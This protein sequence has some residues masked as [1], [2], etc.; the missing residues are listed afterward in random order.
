MGAI[1][2]GFYAS[3]MS[4]S[5]ILDL[6]VNVTS[7]ELLGMIRIGLPGGSV[8]DG[9]WFEKWLRDRTKGIKI[10]DCKIPFDAIAFDVSN[11]CSVLID[12]GP[13]EAAMRASSALPFIFD[14]YISQGMNLVD[15]GVEHPLP[16]QFAHFADKRS[17]VIALN[18]LPEISKE[19]LRKGLGIDERD[20][21]AKKTNFL[22]NSLSTNIFNQSSI[23]LSGVL[24]HKPYLYINDYLDGKEM[25]DIGSANELYEHGKICAEKAI[26]MLK[27]DESLIDVLKERFDNLVERFR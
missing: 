2:G 6:A 3:G 9:R 21:K 7:V 18:S 17:D 16:L 20:F 14:P 15:G 27:S 13:L 11:R 5:G 10:E 22:Y 23:A 25:W 26:A 4:A 12:K 24:Y 1:I 8:L 19:A